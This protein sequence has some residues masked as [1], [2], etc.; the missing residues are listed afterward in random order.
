[1]Y[2]YWYKDCQIDQ[3]EI[4]ISRVYNKEIVIKFYGYSLVLH[5][6]FYPQ[7]FFKNL[8]I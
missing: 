4:R 5:F 1:M 3:K 6:Y 7:P 8:L 2:L